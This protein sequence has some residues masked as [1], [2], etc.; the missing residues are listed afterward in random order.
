MKRQMT[1]NEYNCRLYIKKAWRILNEGLNKLQKDYTE[2]K[3][4]DTDAVYLIEEIC[5]YIIYTYKCFIYNIEPITLYDWLFNRNRPAAIALKP[6]I[7]INPPE[8]PPELPDDTEINQKPL[9]IYDMALLE[10]YALLERYMAEFINLITQANILD[11]KLAHLI[12]MIEAYILYVELCRAGKRPVLSFEEW[13]NQVTAEEKEKEKEREK[14]KA[15][16]KHEAL[17]LTIDNAYN[18]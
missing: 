17:S 5:K 11:L 9:D 14:K 6:F 3:S 10:A 16:L 4:I 18:V 1:S 12:R 15:K 7:P 8:D 13:L 2:N